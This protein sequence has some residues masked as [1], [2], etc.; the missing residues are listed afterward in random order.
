MKLG[1]GNAVMMTVPPRTAV[2]F[3]SQDGAKELKGLKGDSVLALTSADSFVEFLKQQTC[4]E[5]KV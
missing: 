1:I 4:L 5:M 2:V 3:T